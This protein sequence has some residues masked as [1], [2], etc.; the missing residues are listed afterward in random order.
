MPTNSYSHY[1]LKDLY[2]AIDLMDRKIAHGRNSETLESA[3]TQESFL[4][5]LVAK[6]AALVKS[7]LILSEQGVHC[8]AEF[9]PRSFIHPVQ[10]E[11]GT[12]TMS[13]VVADETT[14]KKSLRPRKKRN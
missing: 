4:R 5:K 10:D 13:P 8:D 14:N 2:Q 11:A 12:V 7:A 1:A 3:E 9:L 6:R